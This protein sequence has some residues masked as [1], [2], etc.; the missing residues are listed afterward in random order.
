M[1]LA[2]IA[3][4]AEGDESELPE[5]LAL[6]QRQMKCGLYSRAALGFFEAG[7]ADRVVAQTL[8][9]AF[10][11]VVDRHSARLAARNAPAQ[12]R[13]VIGP[14]PAYFTSVLDELLT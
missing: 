7:F 4:L 14:F 8:A 10:P 12:L 9:G 13:E 11:N 6:F 3:D 5:M 1:I 2:T